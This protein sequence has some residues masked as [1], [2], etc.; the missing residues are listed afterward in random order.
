MKEILEIK[1]RHDRN[2]KKREQ[3]KAEMAK[4]NIN[5]AVIKQ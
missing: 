2:V 3:Q 5:K 1:R 4:A